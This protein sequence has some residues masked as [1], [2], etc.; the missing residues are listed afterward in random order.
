MEAGA[1]EEAAMA[2]ESAEAGLE[3]IDRELQ[4]WLAPLLVE[5]AAA[6]TRFR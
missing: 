3:V 1:S 5:H 6:R 2:G 4:A